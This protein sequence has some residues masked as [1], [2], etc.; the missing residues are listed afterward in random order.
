MDDLLKVGIITSTHGIHGEV[1]VY[2]TTDDVNRFKKLK[3]C[4]I[5]AKRES[6]TVHIENCKFFKNMVIL[7]FKEYSNIN[8]VEIFRQCDLYVTRENA[9]KCN[10]DE[11]FIGDIIDSIILDEEGNNIGVLTEVLS[12]GANDVYII[13]QENEKEILIP[14][15]KQ[16]IINVD[17]DN[18]VIT[19][20]LMEGLV[21]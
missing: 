14:A 19:V 1:K 20:R 6:I 3:E 17:L 13:K 21:D 4:I 9:I 11:Y 8:E 5:A 15:I 7:K 16:C 10:K 12:T 2:P 18:K